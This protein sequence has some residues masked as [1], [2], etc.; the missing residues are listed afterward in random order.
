MKKE[1]Q[2][3]EIIVEAPDEHEDTRS[4]GNSSGK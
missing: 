2:I 3:E 1:S 4:L